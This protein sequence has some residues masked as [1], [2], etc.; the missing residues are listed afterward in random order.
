MTHAPSTEE[1]GRGLATTDGTSRRSIGEMLAVLRDRP[2]R[3]VG[4]AL[5]LLAQT[6]LVAILGPFLRPVEAWVLLAV[7]PPWIATATLVGFVSWVERRPLA[8]IGAAW[9]TWSDLWL[10][11]GGAVVG[12][13]TMPLVIPIRNAL[14]FELGGAALML[15]QFPLWATILVVITAAVTE[16]V[17]FRAYPIERVA[18]ITGSVWAGAVFSFVGFVLLHVPAWGVGH[19][20]DISGVSIVLV[21]LYVWRRRLGPVIVMHF[22]TNFVLLVVAPMLGW[23]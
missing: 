1:D 10:G 18:E 6:A 19:V 5:A 21:A 12:L 15:L 7:G 14:G 23:L 11:L 16:E 3:L 4:L 9:P 22:L 13:L 8:S 2:S 17:L 20:I